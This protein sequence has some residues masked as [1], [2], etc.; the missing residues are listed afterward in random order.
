[1]RFGILGPLDLRSDDGTPADPGGPRPRALLTLLLLDA[2][3][4]V[5]VEA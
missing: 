3:R 5:S 4:S 2:G 1:M